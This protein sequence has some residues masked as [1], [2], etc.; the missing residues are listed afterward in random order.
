VV[1]LSG[2]E[3]AIRDGQVY[4]DDRPLNEP[5]VTN[6]TYGDYG[7]EHVP[8]LHIFVL[9]DNR[10]FSNDSRSFGMVPIERVVGRA[11]FSYWPLDRLG[12]VQ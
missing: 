6:F 2:E 11:W 12:F 4:I 3:V 7:P 1:G 5:Y 8:P 9:G 10:G